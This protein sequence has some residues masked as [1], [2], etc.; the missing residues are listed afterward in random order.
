MTRRTETPAP[1]TTYRA[2]AG[3]SYPRP[4]GPVEIASEF[5]PEK[6]RI[7]REIHVEAGTEGLVLP[8]KVVAELLPRGAIEIHPPPPPPPPG[9]LAVVEEAGSV[10]LAQDGQVS[11]AKE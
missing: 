3:I 4:G 2:L 1:Q 9:S 6:K 10:S 11:E 7:S 8:D 5:N